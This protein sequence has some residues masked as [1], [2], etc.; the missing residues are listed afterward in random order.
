MIAV[1]ITLIMTSILNFIDYQQTIY[2][3]QIFGLGAEANPIAAFLLETD[4]WCI[5]K[6]LLVP[7]LLIA[8]GRIVYLERKLKWVVYVL[9]VLYSIVVVNNFVM[10]SRM[11]LF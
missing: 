5:S 7:I 9:F 6:L 3:V 1:I 11:G 2:S 8:M 10:L 4:L